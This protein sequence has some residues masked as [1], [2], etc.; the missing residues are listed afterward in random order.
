MKKLALATLRITDVRE[1]MME[2]PVVRSRAFEL[3]AEQAHVP[4]ED[5]AG[6][7]RILF[8]HAFIIYVLCM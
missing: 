7:Y 8:L 4:S 5:V 3:Q 1:G 6:M 2:A